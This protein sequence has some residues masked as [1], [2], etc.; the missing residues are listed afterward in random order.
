MM[1]KVQRERRKQLLL[2]RARE[3]YE[4]HY[5]MMMG[6]VREMV[7]LSAKIGQYRELTE[8]YV[9]T[10]RNL[11]LHIHHHVHVHDNLHLHAHIIGY[12]SVKFIIF[13]NK[14]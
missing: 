3:H 11:L 5:S 9:W 13:F 6:I 4:K 14:T 7:M 12:G 2:Q 10:R 1:L 8:G